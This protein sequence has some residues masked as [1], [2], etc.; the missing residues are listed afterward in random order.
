[1][2]NL[3]Q[4]KK[5]LVKGAKFTIVEHFI[6]PDWTGQKRIVKN[7]QTNG[8]YSGID[9]D[10]EDELSNLNY[11]K[12]IWLS[13]DKATNWLF[14]SDGTAT[15]TNIRGVKCFTLKLETEGR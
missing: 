12:G 9:G 5:A 10:P 8:I 14:G 15:F 7:V 1:M 2:K 11:G 6:K 3:S 13:F 4:L